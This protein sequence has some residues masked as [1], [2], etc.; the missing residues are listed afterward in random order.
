MSDADDGSAAAR[1]MEEYAIEASLVK[2]AGSEAIDFVV[3]ENVQIHGGNG[4]V[5]DYAAEGRYRDARVNRIFEGTNEINRLAVP[6]QLLRRAARGGLALD[7]AVA[8]AEGRVR[9][10]PAAPG[11]DS[12]RADAT[13]A[14]TVDGFKDAARILIGRAA[15]RHGDRLSSEQ[16]VSLLVAD[17]ILE[18]FAAESV[19]LRAA[20]ARGGAAAALHADV[21]HLY[22]HE[23]ALRVHAAARTA[24]PAIEPEG[25][26][27]AV[28]TL[29][30][31]VPV[32]GGNVIAAQRR[33]ADAVTAVP[34]YIFSIT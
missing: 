7:E 32:P 8:Q 18:A 29:V 10:Q 21:A 6:A 26:P 28:E 23:A 4:F 24:L 12:S 34:R 20:Q 14:D 5:A 15:A 22:V 31:L 3:D 9:R 16:E 33:I 2:I 17:V 11:A 25:A 1:A 13:M 27:A 30:A 19:A